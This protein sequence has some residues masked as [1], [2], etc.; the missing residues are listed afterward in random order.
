MQSCSYY[1]RVLHVALEVRDITGC[2]S[3]KDEFVNVDWCMRVGLRGRWHPVNN[4]G[5]LLKRT[6][7]NKAIQEKGVLLPYSELFLHFL[8]FHIFSHFSPFFEWVLW[9]HY[10]EIH[11]PKTPH[12]SILFFLICDSHNHSPFAFARVNIAINVVW[13]IKAV[14]IQ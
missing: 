14:S 12:F 11:I 9:L 7:N 6:R 8:H 13:K 2:E 5:R 4:E 10:F 1:N 3:A